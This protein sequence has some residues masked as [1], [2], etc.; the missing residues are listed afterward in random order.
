[1]QERVVRLEG[2]SNFRDYGGYSTRGGGRMKTGVLYR[3]ANHSKAS[4]AD[5]EAIAVLGI[6]VVVDLRR[7]GERE[8]D[9]S[10]RHPTFAGQ[11]IDNDIGDT[12]DDPWLMFVSTSDLSIESFRGHGL[13]YY[14][15]APFEAR[16]ID[17]YSR[18]FRA[19]AETDQAVLIHCAA[20]KD[21]TGL[22]AALTHHL[23]GVHPD[24]IMADYLLTNAAINYELV[25]PHVT[26]MLTARAGR[27][28][29]PAAVRVAI[30][31]DPSYLETS[32]KVIR[33]AHGDLDAYLERVL[34]VDAGLRAQLEQR[35]L[36]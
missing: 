29:D 26:E 7:R 2:V 24:D 31:V 3:S 1:M 9:P 23:V 4:D 28:P 6:G 10:R 8:R 12:P 17:L 20:G 22:L 13:G 30:G 27:A 16:H 33:D 15:D 18:Y 19:L 21:R 35:L 11:V 25:V 32:F 14:R 36:A 34:G 5:L